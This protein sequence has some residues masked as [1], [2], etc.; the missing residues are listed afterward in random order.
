MTLIFSKFCLVSSRLSRRGRR[1]YINDLEEVCL[2]DRPGVNS[3]YESFEVWYFAC[4]VVES[5]AESWVVHDILHCVQ[6]AHISIWGVIQVRWGAHRSLMACASRRGDCSQSRNSRL[7]I[8][9]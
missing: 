8:T 6:S 2:L 5:P 9:R 3:G 7:P 1:A 4:P